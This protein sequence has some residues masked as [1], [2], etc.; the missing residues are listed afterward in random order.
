[1]T[2]R[3]DT[4][5]SSL[6]PQPSSEFL[7]YQTEDGRTRIETRLANESV[8]LT[9]NQM[10]ELFQRDKSVISRHIRNVF[11]EGELG[12]EGVVAESATT[13][14]DGKVYRVKE[15]GLHD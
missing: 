5:P 12:R 13:A 11:E 10:A 15:L 3:E 7:I 14:A 4:H 9:L 6:I 8:W 2:K 1:M